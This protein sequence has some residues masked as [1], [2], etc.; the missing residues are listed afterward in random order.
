MF[1]CVLKSDKELR[2]KGRGYYNIKLDPKDNIAIVKWYDNKR[3][4]MMSYVGVQAKDVLKRWSV[5]HESYVTRVG[6][7]WYISI[8]PTWEG[9][10]LLDMLVAFYR[11]NL[12]AKSHY[13]QIIFHLTDVYIVNGWLLYKWHFKQLGMKPILLV[14]FRLDIANA[15]LQAEKIVVSKHRHQA[16]QTL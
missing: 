3:V 4:Y 9:G 11:I 15:L 8:I 7:W 14:H 1:K 5:Q 6:L 16:H 2:K 12:R 10:D 13:L